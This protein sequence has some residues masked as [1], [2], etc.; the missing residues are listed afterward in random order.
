MVKDYLQLP[1]GLRA[2]LK[3]PLGTVVKNLDPS[4]I[5]R[6][7]VVSVGDETSIK[8]INLG[9]QPD[10]LIYD[11]RCQRKDIEIPEKLLE[12]DATDL[13]IEN[14]PGY[15]NKEIFSLL[16]ESFNRKGKTRIHVR[17]EEDLIALAAISIAPPNS[18]V[19][20]GQPNEGTVVVD[21]DEKI[22]KKV[23][24]IIKAMRE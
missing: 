24:D 14:P 15:L 19:L 5:Y 3:K 10:I 8:L 22:K 23:N 11:G 9:F 2:Q 18:V 1:D 6:Q 12:Y 17:G 20:Y 7:L 4:S 16:E 13:E 21:V